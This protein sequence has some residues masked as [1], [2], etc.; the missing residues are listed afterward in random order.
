MKK[1]QIKTKFKITGLVGFDLLRTSKNEFYNFL[2][3]EYKKL[4]N[5]D[6]EI[7]ECNI[8]LINNG[9]KIEILTYNIH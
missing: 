4:F 6:I 7:L 2:D 3:N 5:V 8:L 1:V 9:V